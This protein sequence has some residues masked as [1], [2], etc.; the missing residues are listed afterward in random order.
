MVTNTK[1]NFIREEDKE[2]SATTANTQADT[3]VNVKRSP[4]KPILPKIN[5]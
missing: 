4:A 2:D 1:G 3:T 5:R